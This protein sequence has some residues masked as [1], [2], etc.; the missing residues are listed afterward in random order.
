MLKK[1]MVKHKRGDN[2]TTWRASMEIIFSS[3][4]CDMTS[5]EMSIKRSPHWHQC[6][7][8]NGR[9]SQAHISNQGQMIMRTQMT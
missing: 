9:N 1:F 4:L 8:Y 3:V 2:L 6:C 5:L 7:F